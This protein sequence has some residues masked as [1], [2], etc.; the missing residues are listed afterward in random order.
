M[1]HHCGDIGFVADV[2]FDVLKTTGM[3]GYESIDLCDCSPQGGNGDVGHENGGALTE[4]QD[5]CL[6]TNASIEEEFSKY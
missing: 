3:G 5:C 4:K 1:S 2:T 6:K